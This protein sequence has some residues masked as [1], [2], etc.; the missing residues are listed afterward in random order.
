MDRREFMG[1]AAGA[2]GA[3]IAMGCAPGMG[4]SAPA[5]AFDATRWR[6]ARRFMATKQGRI[7]Y[8]DHGTGPVALFLHGFPLNGFQWRG[9]I[10]RL[11]GE[12]RCIAP[13]FLGLGYTEVAVG[14]GVDPLTQ[15]AMLAELLDKLSVR[16]V[17]IIAND[18][19]GAVAQLLL[20]RHPARVR[21]LLLTNCD[22]EPDSPPPALMPVIESARAGRFVDDWL[23]P[24]HA[25]KEFARSATALG[26]LC[27]ADPGQ[28]TDEALETYLTPLVAAA[29]KTVTNAY[30]VALSPNP[31]AG[32]T[33]ELAK[34]RVPMRVVW[35]VA[36][37]IFAKESP[38]YLDRTFPA[39]RGVRL[40]GGRK[41]F[42]PEELPEVVAEEART[43]WR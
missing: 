32:I 20:V 34:S 39:S 37:E 41:L 30:A 35:G 9:A 11:A 24:M 28:P 26:G 25:D 13:D 27:Y 3:S 5:M 40:L 33:A 10:D 14:G 31:L 6:E 42:W 2:T 16:D 38:E 19:G 8:I 1:L 17:D 36:D 4:G 15:V 7:A 12:R 23:V 21:T 43:L 18:S 22:V 29:Q